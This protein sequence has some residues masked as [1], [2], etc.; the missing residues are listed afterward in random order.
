MCHHMSSRVTTFEWIFPYNSGHLIK[1]KIVKERYEII[2][3]GHHIQV[4]IS[5]GRVVLWAHRI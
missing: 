5:P 3:W 2:F 1:N 4:F